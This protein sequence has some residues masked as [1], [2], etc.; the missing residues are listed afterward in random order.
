MIIRVFILF[1]KFLLFSFIMEKIYLIGSI[2]NHIN[3]DYKKKSKYNY[4]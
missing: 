2:F 4:Q 3:L 1:N